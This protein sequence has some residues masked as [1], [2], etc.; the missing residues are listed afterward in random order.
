MTMDR[1]RELYELIQDGDM[2]ARDELIEGFL[3]MVSNISNKMCFEEDD[4]DDIY[5]AGCVGLVEA[6]NKWDISKGLFSTIAF[7]YIWGYIQNHL[8][9]EE[10]LIR[11]TEAENMI[12]YDDNTLYETLY[13]N[14]TVNCEH[15]VADKDLVAR[16]MNVLNAKEQK[17]IYWKYYCGYNANEIGE[18][19]SKTGNNVNSKIYH[20]LVKLRKAVECRDLT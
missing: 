20:A 8:V 13:H 14:R 2:S 6:A 5:Q 12:E 1:Q 11:F 4:Y 7:H 17:L 3:R 19:I 16:I 15:E 18:L 9:R 10:Q